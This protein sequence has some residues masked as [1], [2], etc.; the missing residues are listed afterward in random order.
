[1]IQSF[2]FHH[3][4]SKNKQKTKQNQARVLR[5]VVAVGIDPVTPRFAVGHVGLETATS[6]THTTP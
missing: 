6:K 3:H 4:P 1:M 2:F 5:K